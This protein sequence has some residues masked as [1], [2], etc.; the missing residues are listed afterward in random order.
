MEVIYNTF[1]RVDNMK[2][3][4]IRTRIFF[5]QGLLPTV[6]TL[7]FLIMFILPF[8]SVNEYSILKNTT[9]HL[10]AQGAPYAWVMNLVFALL[11]IAAV[12]D[13][14]VRLQKFWLHKV[15]LTIF[16]ISLILV[17]FFQHAPIVSGVEFS[18]LEDDLHSKFATTI[19]YSFVFFA[20][21]AAFIE[22][23]R[24]RSVIA[25]GMGIIA[26]LLSMLIFN[27]SEL[28]GVWQRLM[29]IIMFAWLMFFLYARTRDV[30]V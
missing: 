10:G 18:A 7:M 22:L 19:G 17:A 23:T 8:F 11:G 26:I 9:S 30:H 13:G 12:V 1:K 14:W 25:A 21:S 24:I 6:Y 4:L 29:F 15:V 16:G 20:I 27:V 3:F 5:K 2:P 28:A